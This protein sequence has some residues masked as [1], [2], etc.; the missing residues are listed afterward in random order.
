MYIF[1]QHSDDTYDYAYNG[2]G[3]RLS[4]IVN[5]EAT[6]YTLDTVMGL[7][8][9]L[10][11]GTNTYLYGLDR[12]GEQ[13]PAGWAYHLPDALGSVRQLTDADAG[14]TLA[15][16]YEPF[17][18]V[19]ASSGL[20]ET[21]YS[22]TGEWA[23]GTGLV[24]LRAR[25]YAPFQGGFISRDSWEQDYKQPLSINRWLY[26]FAQPISNVDPSGQYPVDYEDS[27]Y[28][29]CTT[30][31]DPASTFTITHVTLFLKSRPIFGIQL[32]KSFLQW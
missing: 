29:F 25:Y 14:V 17:G 12:V 3:D 24:H 31:Y 1:G 6:N 9:V 8:Q 16:S 18:S 22:F 32:L 19:M 4:Q 23:D 5:G 13:Q 20:G 15:R 2:L 7:T 10:D 30:N 28:D 26:A 11:D 21:N 27:N